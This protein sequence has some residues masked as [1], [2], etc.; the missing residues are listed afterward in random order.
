[1]TGAG[2]GIGRAVSLR[3]MALGAHVI[4]VGRRAPVLESL[5]GPRFTPRAHDLRTSTSIL[6]GIDRLHLLVN[7]AGGQFLAPLVDISP[8]GWA[9]VVD[10]NLT[11]LA[12][13]TLAA[14]PLLAPGGSVVNLSLSSAESGIP[15]NAHS[16]AARA[17]VIG[18]TRAL[19]A[20]WRPDGIRVNCLAPG[21]VLTDG[22]RGEMSPS[23]LAAI[24]E[25]TPLGRDTTLDEVAELVAL[26]AVV[27]GVTGQVL[28]LD[29]GSTLVGAAASR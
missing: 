17:G 2:T 10:L 9:A 29:G 8:R 24:V 7:N 26:L 27:P 22:V 1:V 28:A 12:R 3:L 23:A 18:L 14:R 5:A 25:R 15:G 20:A 13:L 19:A 6:D 21:T 16:A 4:G 11:A